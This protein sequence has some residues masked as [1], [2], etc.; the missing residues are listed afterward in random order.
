M[1]NRVMCS[2]ILICLFASVS[3]AAKPNFVVMLC[4]D[5]GYGELGCQGNPEIPTPSIDSIAA[6]A[7]TVIRER[8]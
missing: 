5:L 1:R 2:A 8:S 3:A 6:A 7:L 4:D